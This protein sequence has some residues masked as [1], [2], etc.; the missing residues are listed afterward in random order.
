M[1]AVIIAP[2]YITSF[3]RVFEREHSLCHVGMVL[4][5]HPFPNPV[6][7]RPIMKCSMLNALAWRIAPITITD[8]PI[9]IIRLRPRG[10]LM[11]IEMMEPRKHPKL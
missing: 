9:M 7:I 6:I 4:V 3:P 2:W 8:V 10:L 5:P 1:P 11:K